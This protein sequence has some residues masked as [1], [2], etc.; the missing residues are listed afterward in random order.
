MEFDVQKSFGY[1]VL[2]TIV[3]GENS[4]ELSDYP[5]IDFSPSIS[6]PAYQD[7][8][9]DPNHFHIKY[10]M[11]FKKPQC[12]LDA[13][14]HK[15]ASIYLYV[16][17]RKTFY[18][19]LHKVTNLKDKVKFDQGLFRYNIEASSF[20]IANKDFDLSSNEFHEDF[21]K[22]P[23]SIKTGDVLAWSSPKRYSAEKE[24]YR[25]IRAMMD[26][27]SSE[28]VIPGEYVLKTEEEHVLIT[29]HPTFLEKL[30][31]FGLK[32]EGQDILRAS[33]I[34]PVIIELLFL[35]KEDKSLAENYLWASVLADKCDQLNVDLG[36]PEE[37]SNYAQK[38]LSMPL[39]NLVW[40]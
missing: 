34:V 33:L 39:K 3:Q 29:V 7:A 9:N 6:R 12:L 37:F 38:L 11:T 21:G 27:S 22:G 4:G 5:R 16:L 8:K 28:T 31:I 18:S 35:L 36:K 40:S 2:R 24:T 23:F 17:C 14:E 19:K 32:R 30:K 20:I 13:I 15:N 25:S 26:Y 10:D 1:P